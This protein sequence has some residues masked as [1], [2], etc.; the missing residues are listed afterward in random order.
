MPAA[1]DRR[2][3]WA[4]WWNSLIAGI[5]KNADVLFDEMPVKHLASLAVYGV[6]YLVA[7]MDADLLFFSEKEHKKKRTGDHGLG[8]ITIGNSKQLVRQRVNRKVWWYGRHLIVMSVDGDSGPENSTDAVI[9]SIVSSAASASLH[10]T[11]SCPVIGLS[12]MTGYV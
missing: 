12:K 7:S 8:S 2:L 10:A 4:R 6:V 1:N 9:V 3:W 11:I 5:T